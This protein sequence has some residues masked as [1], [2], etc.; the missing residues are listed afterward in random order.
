[1]KGHPVR[2]NLQL[3]EQNVKAKATVIVSW[4]LGLGLAAIT[5]TSLCANKFPHAV[6]LTTAL[7]MKRR[8]FLPST[9]ASFCH[10]NWP[11]TCS[12]KTNLAF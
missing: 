7:L 6:Q 4:F 8:V 9:T 5:A 12:R 10:K 1:M 11:L 2:I 3:M